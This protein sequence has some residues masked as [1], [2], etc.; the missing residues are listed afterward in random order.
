MKITITDYKSRFFPI[1]II[2]NNGHNSNVFENMDQVKT[3]CSR[4]SSPVFIDKR[5]KVN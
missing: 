4:F 1:M 3:Y 5:K 2:W